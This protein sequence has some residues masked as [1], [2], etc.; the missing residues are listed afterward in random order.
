MMMQANNARGNA[1]AESVRLRQEVYRSDVEKMAEWMEDEE[2]VRY[3][4]E[5]QDIEDRL[6]QTLRQTNLPIF[7]PQLSR[8]GSFFLVTLPESGPIGFLRL[9]PKEE[10]TEIVIVIGERSQ[11]GKSYGYQAV[12]KGVRVAFFRWREEKVIAKIHEENERSK[13]LFRKAGFSREGQMNGQEKFTVTLDEY[14]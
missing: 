10:G 3:L 5:E 12:K 1:E 6:H 13:H 4:N 14:N 2:V 8:N 7:S 11:W 9:I